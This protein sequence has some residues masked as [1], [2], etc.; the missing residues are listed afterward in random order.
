MNT[1]AG[2]A[3]LVIADGIEVGY[4][5]VPLIRAASWTVLPGTETALTGRSGSG[6]TTLLLVLAGLLAPL[7]GGVRWPGL[8]LDAATRSG[9]IGLVFQAPS[10]LAE[11]TARENVA[12]PL[13][14]RGASRPGA[15]QAAADAL[16][17]VGLA[18]AAQALP[19]QLS[20]GQQQRVAVARV[21]AGSPRLVL[22]DEPTGALDRDNAAAVLTVLRD[23]VRE[24]GGALIV[25]THD[26]ELAALLAGNAAIRDGRLRLVAEPAAKR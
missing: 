17:A 11:L 22:A 16:A 4:R 9:Q 5:G 6:K 3:P 7:I 21:I 15:E 23:S 1:T 25:A 2:T 26:E 12:L 19:A 14:L 13:R 24:S 10:L 8:A 18:G 20:G